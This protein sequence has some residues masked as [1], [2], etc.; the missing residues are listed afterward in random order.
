MLTLY[1]RGFHP[2]DGWSA[3][4]SHLGKVKYVMIFFPLVVLLTNSYC[5][6][7]LAEFV[8]DRYTIGPLELLCD[9]DEPE[10]CSYLS[11]YYPPFI[12]D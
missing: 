3:V 12:P 11:Q 6:W 4:S 8:S 10:S 1:R 9:I 5:L 2:S 7:P